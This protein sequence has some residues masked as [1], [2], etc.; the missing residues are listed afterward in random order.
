MF[1]CLYWMCTLKY[2]AEEMYNC[3]LVL[4]EKEWR[5]CTILSKICILICIKKLAGN[6]HFIC[7]YIPL[8][9]FFFF[10]LNIWLLVSHRTKI[11]MKEKNPKFSYV[12]L[13]ASSNSL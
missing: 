1:V 10:Y 6:T 13:I 3:N 5:C 8:R 4:E 9:L 11:D 2:I 12:I 7:T